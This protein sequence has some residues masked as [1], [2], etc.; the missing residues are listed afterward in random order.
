M[1]IRFLLY[2]AKRVLKKVDEVM[3]NCQNLSGSDFY[4]IFVPFDINPVKLY[5]TPSKMSV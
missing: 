4:A 1:Y 5:M 3:Q 2:F